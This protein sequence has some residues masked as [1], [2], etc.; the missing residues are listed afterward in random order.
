MFVVCC[1]GWGPCVGL[2]TR[3]EDLYR[4]CACAC[5]CVCVC[6]RVWVCVR[7]CVLKK[8]TMRRRKLI[9]PQTKKDRKCT[10][11]E[12]W[13]LFGGFLQRLRSYDSMI[14]TVRSFSFLLSCFSHTC[15]PPFKVYS[16][17]SLWQL[18]ILRENTKSCK[19]LVQGDTKKTG[20]FEKPNKKLKKSKKK[21]L[22]T[23]IEP[24][25]LA[26]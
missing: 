16:P 2:I 20:T 12:L 11:Y 1:V 3:S 10:T 4:L 19:I 7:F 26:F 9:A 21:N 18:F 24:L 25:Q 14:Y 5:A 17:Y 13:H 15:T 22:L 6:L 8:S 23:E